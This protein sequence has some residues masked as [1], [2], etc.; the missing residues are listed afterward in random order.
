M[1]VESSREPFGGVFLL[2]QRA[3]IRV[4]VRE[5][6]QESAV[7]LFAAADQVTRT[8][9]VV[10]AAKGRSVHARWHTLRGSDASGNQ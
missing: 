4:A 6:L 2:M 3:T 5:A 10:V 8:V 7:S 1:D 9:V